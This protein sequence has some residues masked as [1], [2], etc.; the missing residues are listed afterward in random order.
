MKLVMHW[1]WKLETVGWALPT[2]SGKARPTFDFCSP[3]LRVNMNTAQQ[4]N[5]QFGI[6]GQLKFASSRDAACL[7]DPL[8]EDA[9]VKGTPPD[10]R[11]VGGLGAAGGL[12]IA[13]I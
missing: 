5:A 11:P 13:E 10:T 8:R 4:L 7:P 2:M 1:F 9:P 6:D 12:I 3:T